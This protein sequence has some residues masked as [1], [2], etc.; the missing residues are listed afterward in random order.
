M[1]MGVV[2]LLGVITAVAADEVRIDQ[3]P[4]AVKATIERETKG[5]RIKEIERETKNGRTVYEVE[6]E[7]GGKEREIH[8]AEDGSVLKRDK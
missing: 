5:G 2:L 7:E 1:I 6:F 3:V 4:A 8:V